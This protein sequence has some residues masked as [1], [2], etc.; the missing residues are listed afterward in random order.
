MD[1]CATLSNFNKVRDI[2]ELAS[3]RTSF[4]YRWCFADSLSRLTFRVKQEYSSQFALVLEDLQDLFES[5]ELGHTSYF[6]SRV[7]EQI[8]FETPS[9]VVA[10]LACVTWVLDRWDSRTALTRGYTLDT[11]ALLLWKRVLREGLRVRMLECRSAA[12][13]AWSSSPPRPRNRPARR[14]SLPPLPEEPG[15]TEE[16]EQ[17]P[18]QPQQE[19]R[20][21]GGHRRAL[22]LAL[23]APPMV[24]EPQT[25]W[26]LRAGLDPPTAREE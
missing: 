17:Q 20:R 15:E 5:L 22:P 6:N 9:R 12:G 16:E 23:P 25:E 19:P 18:Q 7:V 21:Q 26:P 13:R 1:L 14:P 24:P 2:L 4:L 3:N 8:G 11:C 10:G